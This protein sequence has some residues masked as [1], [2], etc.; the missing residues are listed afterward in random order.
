[1]ER[2]GLGLIVQLSSLY[3]LIKS[4]ILATHREYKYICLILLSPHNSWSSIIK[5]VLTIHYIV[6]LRMENRM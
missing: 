1:M 6:G 5:V 2:F 3:A 4:F